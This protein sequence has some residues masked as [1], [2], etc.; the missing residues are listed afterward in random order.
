VRPAAQGSDFIHADIIS[1]LEQSDLVLCDM[2]TLNANVFFELGIRTALNLSTCMVRDSHPARVPFDVGIIN[3]HTYNPSLRP[4]I[5]KNELP[6]LAVHIEK[7]AAGGSSNSLWR[8]LGLAQKASPPVEENPVE[9]KLDLA[10]QQLASLSRSYGNLNPK[11]SSDTPMYEAEELRPLVPVL[12]GQNFIDSVTA[13]DRKSILVTLKGPASEG[14]VATAR[15]VL[16]LFGINLHV[17]RLYDTRT[18]TPIE[19]L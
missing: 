7:A 3:Y 2:S 13:M 11:V 8:R 18:P 14:R 17:Q 5:V 10:L 4:W 19:E 16:K 12:V 9:A 6:S 15:S 1:N